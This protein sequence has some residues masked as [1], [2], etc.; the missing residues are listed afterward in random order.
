MIDNRF[1]EIQLGDVS[2]DEFSD[3]MEK[4]FGTRPIP[5]KPELIPA[6][7]IEIRPMTGPDGRLFI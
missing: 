3:W 6:K 5:V 1:L 2:F 7:S 4:T